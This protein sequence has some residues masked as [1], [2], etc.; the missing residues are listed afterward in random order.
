ML[1]NAKE[2]ERVAPVNLLRICILRSF[3]D[4]INGSIIKFTILT[5]NLFQTVHPRA[6]RFFEFSNNPLFANLIRE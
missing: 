3:D 4:F 6:L 1:S 2:M 5:I